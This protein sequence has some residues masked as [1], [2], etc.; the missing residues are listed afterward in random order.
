VAL[1]ALETKELAARMPEPGLRG[2]KGLFFV[3]L[4]SIYEYVIINSF[5]AVVRQFNGYAIPFERV[6]RSLL[7]MGLHPSF[8]AIQDLSERRGWQKRI[9][10][11]SVCN[12]TTPSSVQENLFPRDDSHFRAT[13]LNLICEILGLPAGALV[14]NSPIIGWI[15]EVVENRNAISHGRETADAIGGR[16][17][18][19]DLEDRLRQLN[20]LANHILN[21]LETH[22]SV[23]TNFE[24]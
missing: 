6:R 22:S 16:Y 3:Q 23:Q 12:S 21:V 11:L 15:D 24:L 14:P 17:S 2:I 10:L 18:S 20:L 7:C 8:Q 5:A 4:Y 19:T 13:Q 1:K 9:E